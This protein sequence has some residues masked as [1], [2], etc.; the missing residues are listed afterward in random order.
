MFSDSTEFVKKEEVK[1]NKSPDSARDD[2]EGPA[3]RVN[4]LTAV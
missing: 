4:L 1:L 2:T 3:E